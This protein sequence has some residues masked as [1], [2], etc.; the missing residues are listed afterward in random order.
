MEAREVQANLATEQK[1]IVPQASAE[2][3]TPMGMREPSVYG[4]E[5][6]DFDQQPLVAPA[7]PTYQG[8][9]LL[10]EPEF[11]AN[12]RAE[13]E[14]SRQIAE[15]LAKKERLNQAKQDAQLP[16]IE[17]SIEQS[18]QRADNVLQELRS[19]REALNHPAPQL[20]QGQMNL[21]DLLAQLA[22]VLTGGRADQLL[23]AGMEVADKRNQLAYQNELQ[24]FN[25]THEQAAQLVDF[26]QRQYM[27][28]QGVQRGLEELGLRTNIE[29]RQAAEGRAWQE[30]EA[31]K[32]RAF[33]EKERAWAQLYS[34]N[35]DGEVLAAADRLRQLDP[36]NAPGPDAV[37]KAVASARTRREQAALEYFKQTVQRVVDAYQGVVPDSVK[38]DLQGRVQAIARQFDVDAQLFGDIPDAAYWKRQLDER[39]LQ[40]KKLEW[41]GRLKFLKD[42]ERNDWLVDMARISV[43]RKQAAIAQQ[44]ANTASARLAWQKVGGDSKALAKK[45]NGQRQTKVVK[46]RGIEK[47]LKYIKD[48]FGSKVKDKQG[49]EQVSIRFDKR[50]EYERLQLDWQQVQG[51]LEEIDAALGETQ[52]AEQEAQ[53][54]QK[55]ARVYQT[56]TGAKF[57]IGGG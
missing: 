5:V 40:A 51:E 41:D 19:A 13:I 46:L 3:G 54:A 20:V 32:T 9:P 52:A 18:R 22:G 33:N 16:A 47:Q 8:S 26:L 50:A 27:G 11:N 29:D 56:Q 4:E 39:E 37:S 44:N 24:Q 38:A 55:P 48:Q 14:L 2:P 53:S 43:S 23:G 1:G 12:D 36:Q 34:S 35:T 49:R 42:K 57:T 7:E 6:K 45:I 28:E 15:G 21:G 30:G 10:L 31:D 25:M 17:R